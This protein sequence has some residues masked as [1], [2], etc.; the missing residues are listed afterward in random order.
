MKV[1]ALPTT[2]PECNKNI[3]GSALVGGVFKMLV[4]VECEHLLKLKKLALSCDASILQDVP[5]DIG[6][7]AKKREKNWWTNHGLPYCM[8]KIE[9]ENRVS[10]TTMHLDKRR[11]VVV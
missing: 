3:T 8:Q 11:C 7:I 1:R 4:V 6:R 5:D 9:D 10:F 2:F